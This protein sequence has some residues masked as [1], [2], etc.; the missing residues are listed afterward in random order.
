MDSLPSQ[1]YM[2]L[3]YCGVPK[4]CVSMQAGT[5]TSSQ[6][7]FGGMSSKNSAKGQS[8]PSPIYLNFHV[9][10]KVK[11]GVIGVHPYTMD[12]KLSKKTMEQLKD[13]I[14][15]SSLVLTS[16]YGYHDKL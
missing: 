10:F 13:T 14:A 7:S 11:K 4:F 3:T 1:G 2:T 9:P 12:S 6:P 16:H 8:I 15:K 5:K